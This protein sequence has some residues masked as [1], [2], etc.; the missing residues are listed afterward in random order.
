MVVTRFLTFLRE[1]V[2][3]GKLRGQTYT[4]DRL[5]IYTNQKSPQPGNKTGQ[6][7]SI[8]ATLGTKTRY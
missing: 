3:S 8:P 2:G 4:F 5:E 7:R 6:C 1:S